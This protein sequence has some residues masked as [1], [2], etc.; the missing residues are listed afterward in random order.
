MFSHSRPRERAQMGKTT[1]V[2][3]HSHMVAGVHGSS[4]IHHCG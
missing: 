2:N 1:E 4:K 3:C